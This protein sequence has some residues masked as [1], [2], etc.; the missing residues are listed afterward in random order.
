LLGEFLQHCDLAKFAGWRYSMPDL[1]AMHASARSFVQET[2]SDPVPA[3][4]GTPPAAA[5]EATNPPI[6]A[7][8]AVASCGKTV[9]A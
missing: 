5:A 1:E 2:A 4:K 7:N 8:E 3:E 9:S 6:H